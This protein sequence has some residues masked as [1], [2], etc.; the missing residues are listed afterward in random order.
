[1]KLIASDLDGTLLNEHGEVSE[2]NQQMIKKAQDRGLRFVVATGRS[3][4][5][6]EKPL[7]KAGIVSPIICLNGAALYDKNKQLTHEVPMEEEVAKRVL[8]T[9]REEN[10]YLEF[11][12]NKGIYSE[13]REYFLEVLVDIMQSANPNLS[14]EDIREA[15]H[16]RFQMEPVEF[17]DDYEIIFQQKDILVYKILAFS[18]NPDA[19]SSTRE[20]L[21]T[22]AKLAI[23]SSGDINLEFNHPKAQKGIALERLAEMY[24]ISMK[25][26]VAVGDNWN[27]VSMLQRAGKGIAMGNASDEVKELA[28][29][30]TK[31]N[32]ED[33]IAAVIEGIL[34]EK[35]GI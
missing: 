4:E 25:D 5:A 31:R 16:L 11:F 35:R 8:S 12:T 34:N 29:E 26:V 10:M 32:T 1:M 13:S 6:A 24:Q 30:V 22:E 19:L 9:C 33:G 28:D 14:E 27:D 15:A 18:V 7:E 23:T 17:V 2:K 3:R 20:K 21:Q